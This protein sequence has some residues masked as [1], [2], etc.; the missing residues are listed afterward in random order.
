MT[1]PRAWFSTLSI[2]LVACGSTPDPGPE[3]PARPVSMTR[4][5]VAAHRGSGKKLQAAPRVASSTTEGTLSPLA[6]HEAKIEEA[7]AAM[8]RGEWRRAREILKA[9]LEASGKRR[10]M[11]SGP[12][13]DSRT[14][15]AKLDLLAELG[16]RLAG[17][18]PSAPGAPAQITTSAGGR[19]IA[20]I[21]ESR[22]RAADAEGVTELELRRLDGIETVIPKVALSYRRLDSESFSK[23]LRRF[24]EE[25]AGRLPADRPLSAWQLFE[26]AWSFAA[27]AEALV[28]FE[29]TLQCPQSELI[30]SLYGPKDEALRA[31]LAEEL[32][33][34]TGGRSKLERV[35]VGAAPRS[36]AQL[37]KA[38]GGSAQAASRTGASKPDKPESSPKPAP[39]Q[40]SPAPT[41]TIAAERQA[42]LSQF[43][44]GLACY[45]AAANPKLEQD[46]L[47]A[48][49][50]HFDAALD[51]W[52]RLSESDPSAA[53]ALEARVSEMA[54]LQY[55]VIKRRK[56]R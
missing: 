20:F 47:K 12:G 4:P 48:A 52:N 37:A 46:Q 38:T 44:A 36:E 55:D 3:S 23:E 15:L 29:K 22:P 1:T 25:R 35:Q 34:M 31:S 41:E 51:A 18:R 43:E 53:E 39:E 33:I 2:L 32:A 11:L 16:E 42:I 54:Q 17:E 50:R 14:R 13:R 26:R 49:Q 28:W 7:Q 21:L 8:L 9:P 27:P 24:L 6:T 30:L 19:F 5:V 10:D 40:P 45:R 56:L